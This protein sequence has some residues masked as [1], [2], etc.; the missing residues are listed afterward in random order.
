MKNL[1]TIWTFWFVSGM[2]MW[3]GPRLPYISNNFPFSQRLHPSNVWQDEKLCRGRSKSRNRRSLTRGERGRLQVCGDLT[4]FDIRFSCKMTWTIDD[5]HSTVWLTQK[6]CLTWF[7][8]VSSLWSLR[9]LMIMSLDIPDFS[10][11]ISWMSSFHCPLGMSPNTLLNQWVVPQGVVEFRFPRPQKWIMP[12]NVKPNCHRKCGCGLQKLCANDLMRCEFFSKILSWTGGLL[13]IARL[14]RS[15]WPT[16]PRK[17][18]I[19][20]IRHISRHFRWRRRGL[21]TRVRYENATPRS[22]ILGKPP[23]MFDSH[24]STWTYMNHF[25]DIFWY[26]SLEV[27]RWQCRLPG[28]GSDLHRQAA[29][30]SPW[31]W[32]LPVSS[33]ASRSPRST[34]TAQGGRVFFLKESW[35][36]KAPEMPE[37]VHLNYQVPMKSTQWWKCDCTPKRWLRKELW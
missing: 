20:P 16:L 35:E 11:E 29:G 2:H 18:S 34:C 32:H 5:I 1:K 14:W 36:E 9:L 4:I 28:P 27:H 37:Q 8:Y 6:N 31:Q 23:D 7:F 17:E 3:A 13:Y 19:K 33:A 10:N 30:G 24:I 25:G 22:L 12:S 26:H 21:V 15:F